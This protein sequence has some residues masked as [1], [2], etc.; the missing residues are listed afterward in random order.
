MEKTILETHQKLFDLGIEKLGTQ[1]K[2]MSHIRNKPEQQAWKFVDPDTNQMTLKSISTLPMPLEHAIEMVA[3]L[4]LRCQWDKGFY[5]FQELEKISENEIIVYWKV[6]MP[7]MITNRD[8]VVQRLSTNN[9]KDWDYI[10]C[11]NSFVHAKM[12]VN[13]KQ[14]RATIENSYTFLKKV[15]DTK[16]D[17]HFL[18]SVNSKGL[19]PKMVFNKLADAVPKRIHSNL[20]KGYD[21]VK[22]THFKEKK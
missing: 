1:H 21:K 15:D 17:M 9:Y 12:P 8:F 18:L 22:N 20:I 7:T 5:D 10:S 14:V 19:I 6:K 11:S 2:K 16:T 13:K 3:N 4:A